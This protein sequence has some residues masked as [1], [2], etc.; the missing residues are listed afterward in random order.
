MNF[1]K[2]FDRLW[3]WTR[4][5]SGFSR[6]LRGF[7]AG[8]GMML[9]IVVIPLVLGALAIAIIMAIE[10]AARLFDGSI[11]R[12]ISAVIAAFVMVTVAAGLIG[13]ATND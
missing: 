9:A 7:L 10:G 5:A 11:D 1:S 4:S 8:I 12:Q 3:R 13:A 2:A 6:R